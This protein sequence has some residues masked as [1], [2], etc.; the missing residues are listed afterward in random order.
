MVS[1]IDLAKRALVKQLKRLALV[2]KVVVTLDRDSSDAQVRTA[3]RKVSARTHPDHRGDEEHQKVINAAHDAWEDALKGSRGKHGGKRD[4]QNG[5]ATGS[6]ST[7]ALVHV[8][9]SM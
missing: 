2:Y 4:Q 6:G 8:L 3:Y 7:H 9:R 1:A 5:P